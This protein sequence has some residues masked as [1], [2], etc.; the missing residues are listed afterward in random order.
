MR[1]F[2]LC[3]CKLQKAFCQCCGQL[4]TP[5]EGLVLVLLPRTHL[6]IVSMPTVA[7]E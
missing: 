2:L 1:L 4:L 5:P 6:A 3:S 7:T